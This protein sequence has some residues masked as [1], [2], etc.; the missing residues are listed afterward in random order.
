M[1]HMSAGRISRADLARLRTLRVLPNLLKLPLFIAL[2]AML[3]WS[4]W[5]TGSVA[6]RWLDYIAIGYLWMSIVTFMHDA[7]H[8]AMFTSRALNLAFGIVMMIPIFA[9]FI[10]FKTDHLEH[11]RYNRSPRDPDAFM[12]GRRRLPDFLLFY[13]YLAFGGVL[14]FV[15]FNFIYPFTRFH[16]REW[17]IHLFESALKATLYWLVFAYAQRHGVLGAALALWP[18]LFFSLFNSM[19]FVAE[20][21]GTPWDVGSMAGTRTVI[22][23]PVHAF[24]WNNINWHIGHHAYPTVPWYNL[25]ELHR[26]LETQIVASGAR[27]DK[28]YLR[29]YF[30]ALCCGPEMLPATAGADHVAA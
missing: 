25:V 16:R 26:L 24:F 18:I 1:S 4:A 23:N 2:M 15:H 29:V 12:M 6:L 5:T 27:V 10:A 3:G 22:S 21:Y 8:N 19:R 30:K 7:T 13:A 14:S 9:S 28:S 20:H 11:H 17:A